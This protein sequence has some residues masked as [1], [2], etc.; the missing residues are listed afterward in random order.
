MSMVAQKLVFPVRS[1]HGH[2][3]YVGLT[4]RKRLRRAREENIFTTRL[5]VTFLTIL[6]YDGLLASKTFAHMNP[7]CHAS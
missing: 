7:W 5:I 6:Q 1:C 4:R 3:S 2:Q